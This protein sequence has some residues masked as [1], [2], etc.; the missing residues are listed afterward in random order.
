MKAY[1]L[2]LAVLTVLAGALQAQA[3]HPTLPCGQ[4]F[5]GCEAAPCESCES[6][7]HRGHLGRDKIP[8]IETWDGAYW[9][10]CQIARSRNWHLWDNYCVHTSPCPCCGHNQGGM[11]C[12]TFCKKK[13]LFGDCGGAPHLADGVEASEAPPPATDDAPPPPPAILNPTGTVRAPRRLLPVSKRP[14]YDPSEDPES[15]NP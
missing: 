4:R 9:G 11:W 13:C 3:G 10:S 6:C 8:F 14:Y 12:R 5:G 1:G 15:A 7:G 2:G